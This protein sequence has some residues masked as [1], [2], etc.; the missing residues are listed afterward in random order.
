MLPF[1]DTDILLYAGSLDPLDK[2]KRNVA[3]ELVATMDFF[4]STQ[5]IQE[6]ISN[7]LRKPSLGLGEA[8]IR[9][10]YNNLL[11]HLVI[12]VTLPL[13]R[14]AWDIK[15]RFGIS[16]WD[17]TILAAAKEAGCHTLYTED[18]NHGQNY[19][20]VQVVNPFLE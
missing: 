7:V 6:Y 1:F 12:P 8:N 15:Q 4:I 2:E 17:A 18:L 13:V 9:D 3:A 5:V 14:Q 11:P 10:L 16:H 20:G 19:D